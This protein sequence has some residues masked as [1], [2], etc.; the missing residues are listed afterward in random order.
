[1][2]TKQNQIIEEIQNATPS[3]YAEVAELSQQ[4]SSPRARHEARCH[5][6]RLWLGHSRNEL[7]KNL[8]LIIATASQ[9]QAG[10]QRHHQLAWCGKGRTQASDGAAWDAAL[11]SLTDSVGEAKII[12]GVEDLIDNP[13]KTHT[14]LSWKIWEEIK[15]LPYFRFGLWDKEIPEVSREFCDSHKTVAERAKIQR[16]WEDAE[17]PTS[18]VHGVFS[19]V[20]ES[21]EFFKFN[22]ETEETKLLGRFSASDAEAVFGEWAAEQIKDEEGPYDFYG[23]S[24]REKHA[25]SEGIFNWESVIKDITRKGGVLKIVYGEEDPENNKVFLHDGENHAHEANAEEAFKTLRCK[26]QEDQLQ[27]KTLEDFFGADVDSVGIS[28][29]DSL[30]AGNCRE[31]TLD[32]AKSK[33]WINDRS[34]IDPNKEFPVPMKLVRKNRLAQNAAIKAA[35]RRTGKK[36]KVVEEDLPHEVVIS[37]DIDLESDENL[38]PATLEQD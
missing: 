7:E 28:L 22:E 25:L 12:D 5:S 31:G 15:I 29:Q 11:A 34:V 24:A 16:L 20:S 26:Q 37:P 2:N 9:H 14:Y 17:S 27:Q 3:Q 10:S 30:A 38:V 1:M 13:K 21:V 33:G 35:E 32:F 23:L 8:K 4:L 6:V 18:P 19:P 36:F